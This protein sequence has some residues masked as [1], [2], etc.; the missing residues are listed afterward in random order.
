MLYTGHPS[1][2]VKIIEAVDQHF[3]LHPVAEFLQ[4]GC[5]TLGVYSGLRRLG[6]FQRQEGDSARHIQ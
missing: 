1:A 3:N 6:G 5:D 2:L 4:H